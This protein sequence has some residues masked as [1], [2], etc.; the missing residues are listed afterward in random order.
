MN[1]E[2]TQEDIDHD[3]FRD[4]DSDRND[5]ETQAYESCG[6]W[7]QRAKGGLLPLYYCR[8]AGTEQCD[9]ECPLHQSATSLLTSPLARPT[10]EQSS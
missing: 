7:D 2:W 3:M 9:F 4:E 1:S 10:P 6:R 8:L 5:A